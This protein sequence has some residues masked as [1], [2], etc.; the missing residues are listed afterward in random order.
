MEMRLPRSVVEIIDRLESLGYEAYAVGGCVRDTLLGREPEDWDIT[1]SAKPEAV[2]KAFDRTIDTGIEHGTVTVMKNHVGYEVTTYRIDG[3]YEDNRHP[4]QVSFTGNLVDDLERRDFTINAMAYNPKT[5]LV[6]A[7]D[8]TSDLKRRIIRCVGDP[9]K[10][11][12]E[13]ALRMLRAVRF[14]GQLQFT[15]EEKTR[16]AIV[17]RAEHLQNISAERIRVEMTKLLISKDSGQFREVV[18]TGMTAYFLPELDRMMTFEQK[19][20]HHIYTVG[21]HSIVSVEIMNDFLRQKNAEAVESLTETTDRVGHDSLQ[22]RLGII[23]D[24]ID[25]GTWNDMEQV[26][27]EIVPACDKKTHQVLCLTMLLH[28]VAKPDCA[29]EDEQGIRHFHGHPDSGAKLAGQI[30]RRLTFDNDTVNRVKTLIKHHDERVQP[31]KRQIRRAA[32][33]IGREFMPLVTLVQYADILAQNPDKAGEKLQRVTAVYRLFMEMEQFHP[34][35][36]IKELAVTGRDIM[37]E[38][39]VKPGPQIGELLQYLLEQVL[40]Q[41]EQNDRETLLSLAK[42][43][44]SDKIE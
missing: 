21:E 15:I 25:D 42:A 5:G 32:A 35:L 1:T 30:L 18:D 10:R 28:D 34:A 41:P 6:D 29:T 2:K 7:F 27:R 19:N 11:F 39:G 13:D 44:Y 3:E 20:P 17:E 33:R 24:Q 16:Q 12:D 43:A 40:D 36:T 37:T 9:D 4:K 8:G 23:D 38:L 14:S 31:Q 22:E 26:I